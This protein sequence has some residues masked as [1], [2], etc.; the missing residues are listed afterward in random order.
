MAGQDERKQVFDLSFDELQKFSAG[1]PVSA[2]HLNTLVDATNKARQGVASAEQI[3]RSQPGGSIDYAIVRGWTDPD[4]DL[5]DVSLIARNSET[6]TWLIPDA[7]TIEVVCSPGLKAK[8]F[9]AVQWIGQGG[10]IYPLALPRQIAVLAQPVVSVGGI[11]VAMW[12]PSMFPAD[13]L[14]ANSP[15]SDGYHTEG[16]SE[17]SFAVAP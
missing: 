14:P 11:L 8:D 3:V 2:S 16:G 12:L 1:S 4:A 10:E 6:G 7:A 17:V 13:S 15:M 5:I 9:E